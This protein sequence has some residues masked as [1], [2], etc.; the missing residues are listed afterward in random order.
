[1]HVV[2]SV[3]Q[4]CGRR[5]QLGA[6]VDPDLHVV[7]RLEDGDRVARADELADGVGEVE[8]ALAV[9]GPEPLERRPKLPGVENVDRRVDL[10]DRALLVACVAGLDDFLEAPVAASDDPPVVAGVVALEGKDRRGRAGA[11]VSLDETLESLGRD[12]SRV[13][14]HHEHVARE[15]VEGFARSGGR[16][17]GSPWLLLDRDLHAGEGILRIR[18]RDDDERLGVELAHGVD[19]PVD[20]TA[21]EERVQVLRRRRAHASAE[22]GGQDN[23]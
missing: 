6:G 4:L 5:R 23:S 12:R 16:V 13:A 9:L 18:R 22:P 2:D 21:P 20:K 1:M 14:A 19:D 7:V 3:A 15:A 10:G 17:P 11:A 8:L